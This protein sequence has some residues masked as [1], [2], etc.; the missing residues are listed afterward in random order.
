MIPVILNGSAFEKGR[1][2][3]DV[4]IKDLA[5]TVTALMG[6][7]PAKEWEGRALL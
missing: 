2:L 1:E 3:T 6:A 4:S 5:P 7:E